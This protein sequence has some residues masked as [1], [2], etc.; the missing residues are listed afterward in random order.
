M[1]KP[2]CVFE[3]ILHHR[4]L[5]RRE[6]LLL[7]VRNLMGQLRWD[8][9]LRCCCSRILSLR[10]C[11]N[12]S[13]WLNASSG[14]AL[15]VRVWNVHRIAAAYDRGCVHVMYMLYGRV[16]ARDGRRDVQL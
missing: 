4:Q 11:L 13:L 1:H 2:V 5:M 3:Y 7:N 12:L 10:V 15:R 8:E 16:S 9:Q 14:D 6:L